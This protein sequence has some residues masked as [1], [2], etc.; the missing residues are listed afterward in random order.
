[1]GQDGRKQETEKA[2]T[3]KEKDKEVHLWGEIPKRTII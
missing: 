1:L 3:I 2:G